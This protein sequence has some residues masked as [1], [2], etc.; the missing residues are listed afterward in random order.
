MTVFG[1]AFAGLLRSKRTL[2]LGL[3]PLLGVV[4]AVGIAAAAEDPGVDDYAGYVGGLLLPVITAFVSLVLG[5]SALTEQREDRTILYLAQTP[6]PRVRIAAETW[7][8]AWLASSIVISPAALAGVVLGVRV[9]VPAR[10]L[11]GL[12]AGAV[13]AA[14]AY[15]ALAVLLGLLTRRAVIVGMLYVLLW[16]GSVASVASSADRISIAAYG[17]RVAAVGIEGAMDPAPPDVAALVA[18]LV[19]V[20]A[21]AVGIGLAGRRLGR[22]ELP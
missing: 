16:E 21:A 11:A 20:L 2:A 19:L 1:I 4:V 15:T 8:A 5:A 12:V 14:G 3:L 18:V 22:M 13:L 6:L 7:L 9:D 17:R 10:A